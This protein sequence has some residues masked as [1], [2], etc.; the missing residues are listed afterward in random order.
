MVLVAVRLLMAALVPTLL[1]LVLRSQGFDADWRAV[2]VAYLRGSVEIENLAVALREPED[3]PPAEPFLHAEDLHFDLSMS[4]LLAGRTRV[5]RAELSGA[6]LV[7]ERRPDGTMPLFGKDGVEPEP[8]PEEENPEPVDLGAPVAV[9][10][11]RVQ[12]ARVLVRDAVAWPDREWRIDLDVR[13]DALGLEEGP[14]RLEIRANSPGMIDDGRIVLDL[15]L[16]ADAARALLAV[17]LSGVRPEAL[18]PF[19]PGLKADSAVA[20]VD[21]EGR[22]SLEARVRAPARDA[23]EGALT[24]EGWTARAGERELA[25]LDRA[26]IDLAS[27]GASELKL[28]EIAIETCRLH[29]KRDESGRTCVLG[30]AFPS[31]DVPEEPEPAS[32]PGA[33]L[34]F[35]VE[36]LRAS[37]IELRFTDELYE[38]APELGLRVENAEILGFDTAPQGDAPIRVDLSVAFPGAAELATLEGTA[39]PFSAKKGM[40]LRLDVQGIDLA[41]LQPSLREAGFESTLHEGRLTARLTGSGTETPAG[42]IEGD[43]RLDEVRFGD[44]SELFGLGAIECN[45]VSLDPA[46]RALRIREIAVRGT[47]LPLARREDGAV[48]FLGL[49]TTSIRPA[50]RRPPEEPARAPASGPGTAGLP[51][52]EIGSLRVVENH[53][54]WRDDTLPTPV[55]VVFDDCGLEIGPLGFF[56]DPARDGS[57]NAEVRVW[58]RAKELLK[59]L[60]LEGS[61]A[62]RPGPLDLTL[63]IR[64]AASGIRA[65]RLQPYIDPL[66]MEE[67]VQEAEISGALEASIAEESGRFRAGAELRDF[68]IKNA[69]EPVLGAGLASLR[70]ARFGDGFLEIGA[71][72]IAQGRMNV[73][74]DPAGALLALGLRIP[75]SVFRAAKKDAEPAPAAAPQPSSSAEAILASVPGLRVGTAHL[76]D[77]VLAWRDASFDPPV[78]SMARLDVAI[79]GLDTRPAAEPARFQ[80]QVNVG[81]SVEKVDV[82]G[83]ASLAPA[84]ARIAAS[85]R[86]QGLRPGALAPYLP[87]GTIC[88]LEAGALAFDGSIAVTPVSEGGLAAD[89]RVERARLEDGERRLLA[90]ELLQLEVGRSDPAAGELEIAGVR[91]RGLEVDLRHGT[92]GR[93]HAL[94][95]GIGEASGPAQPGPETG[96]ETGSETEEEVEPPRMDFTPRGTPRI[97]LGEIDLSASKLSYQD[98]RLGSDPI[99]L[100]LRL[101]TPP[102]QVIVDRDPAALPPTRFTL[103][104]ALT[105]FVRAWRCDFEAAPWIDE[106]RFSARFLAEGITGGG[107]AAI[108]PSLLVWIDG[109]AVREGTATGS[110][111]ACLRWRRRSP[112]DLDLRG[113]F[114]ADV[115]IG[116]L[117]LRD[118]PGG[119]VLAALDG[120][121]AEIE[122]VDPARGDVRVKTLE[123][124]RPELRAWRAPDGLHFLGLVA[125]PEL[126]PQAPGAAIV[127]AAPEPKA[128]A[129]APPQSRSRGEIRVDELRVHGLAVELRDVAADPPTTVPLAELD[130][131]VQRFTTRALHEPL[132]FRFDAWLGSGEAESLEG[133]RLFEEAALSGRVQ[134]FPELRGHAQASLAGL[135]LLGFRGTAKEGGLEI[136]DGTLDA[137]ARLRFRGQDGIRVDSEF[138][139]TDLDLAEAKSG[140]LETGLDL[141]VPLETVLFLLRNADGEHRIPIGF[142]LDDE[143]LTAGRIAGAATGAA[144][145]VIAS[146]VASAPLRAASSVTD[147]FGLTGGETDALPSA[148]VLFAPGSA[149]LTPEGA[150]ALGRLLGLLRANGRLAVQVQHRLCAADVARAA[151]LANPAEADCVEIATGLRRRRAELARSRAEVAADA[152]ALWGLGDVRAAE[153]ATQRLRSLDAASATT[154]D[155][156]DRVLELLRTGADR[157]KEK[158]TKSAALA[159]ARARIE[160]VRSWIEAQ[161]IEDFADRFEAKSV[162]FEVRE[163]DGGG[164]GGAIVA[165]LRRRP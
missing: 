15:G 58:S 6:E 84:G 114:A 131:S 26:R 139:F 28:S 125:H 157:H 65:R 94:G 49:R 111:E 100:S 99:E 155:G 159:L 135:D 39:S 74:R 146:A 45:G 40:D 134:L 42:G 57:T 19:L 143:G 80:V 93:L 56:G 78:E 46:G 109:T 85:C 123:V 1:Q 23:I 22:A 47:S 43:W 103:E 126:K 51:R 5:T 17:H 148:E 140:P 97:V 38:P 66:G 11:L 120:I 153:E 107:L 12:G 81:D 165:A 13:G 36:A 63:S 62:S 152:R 162:S 137:S 2:R 108:D 25:R 76:R 79:E 136:G 87:S 10:I 145:S 127:P 48:H 133:R 83:T 142:T 29:A 30:L 141:P 82:V 77:A 122:R 71:L 101:H 113:G 34:R 33:P 50:R 54:S 20:R 60:A 158:R 115:K 27:L 8:E 88:D 104:G 154:E 119:A 18:A 117:E 98:E 149:T 24:V 44:A 7:L 35:A 53:L 37:A 105:P 68:A 138:V 112:L 102:G 4:A 59:D 32:T 121:D 95:F 69:G 130:V 41:G 90:L 67:Q 3:R 86:A 31:A 14:G 116:R 73:A 164:G 89:V 21:L 55:D 128:R 161:G 70:D 9:D 61:L 72:E 52:I 151:I 118:A 160:A 156:L 132:S 16:G 92:D 147:L 129:Q 124:R 106:P 163:D 64:G 75:M 110:A 144:A 150:A 91:A 96:S